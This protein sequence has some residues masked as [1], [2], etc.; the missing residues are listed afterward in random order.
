M[1]WILSS[2]HC[3]LCWAQAQ[4]SSWPAVGH[5][6]PYEH[7]NSSPKEY[8]LERFI[9][10]QP[11]RC[12]SKRGRLLFIWCA[13]ASTSPLQLLAKGGG[14][15]ISKD[16]WCMFSH[17]ALHF[18]LFWQPNMIQQPIAGLR[19]SFGRTTKDKQAVCRA[20]AK[21]VQLALQKNARMLL[22]LKKK[23]NTFK[24]LWEMGLSPCLLHFTSLQHL[25][26]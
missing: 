25:Q 24:R 26:P 9:D 7:G 4:C 11:A 6:W 3:Q 20:T 14:G 13:G 2:T 12:S 18:R 23:R 1:S 21:L 19:L 5:V 15:Y 8:A 17:M 22:K 16:S 10:T